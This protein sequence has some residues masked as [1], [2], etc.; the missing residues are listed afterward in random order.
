MPKPKPVKKKGGLVEYAGGGRILKTLTGM[1]KKILAD[2]SEYTEKSFK[3]IETVPDP[4]NEN[5]T[6]VKVVDEDGNELQFLYD[7]YVEDAMDAIE[8]VEFN[9]WPPKA[10]P[11]NPFGNFAVGGKVSKAITALRRARRELTEG[12]DPDYEYIAREIEKIPG[13]ERL[14]KRMRLLSE[15]SGRG[16]R[17]T[18]RETEQLWERLMQQFDE[19]MEKVDPEGT[20]KRRE[21]VAALTEEGARDLPR[22]SGD[23]DPGAQKWIAAEAEALDLSVD[24]FL[25]EAW[26]LRSR[27][28]PGPIQGL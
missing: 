14:G 12:S 11:P 2:I 20:A 23:L 4:G 5:L 18:P 7:N 1:Q 8:E 22:W 17:Y 15:P 19:T 6:A 26:K 28:K 24:E 25:E 27:R 21:G 10:G 16:D 3:D 9:T 13:A